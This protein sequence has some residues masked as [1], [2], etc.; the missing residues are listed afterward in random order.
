MAFTRVGGG[1]VGGG[2]RQIQESETV[3]DFE[4]FNTSRREDDPDELE[5]L[6]AD[7]FEK[8]YA[9]D[10]KVRAYMEKCAQQKQQLSENLDSGCGAV[11]PGGKP[12]GFRRI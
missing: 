6:L 5:A 1:A 9:A 3:K 2:G 4:F 12:C 11:S 10:L 7:E 8:A